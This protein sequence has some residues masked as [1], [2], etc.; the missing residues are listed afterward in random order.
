MPTMTVRISVRAHPGARRE[1]VRCTGPDS[2]EV[3]VRAPARDGRA[4]VDIQRLLSQA[5]SVRKSAVRIVHGQGARE[6]VFA[7]EGLEQAQL[8]SIL[9]GHSD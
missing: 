7:I 3:W 4:N 5:L 8:Q 9:H 2:L 6:K 1:E